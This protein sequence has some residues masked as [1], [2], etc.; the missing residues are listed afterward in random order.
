MDPKDKWRSHPV[1]GAIVSG[2]AILAPFLV[3]VAT[4]AVVGRLL[5]RGHGQ[6]GPALWWAAV[7]VSSTAAFFASERL[8]RRLLPLAA[9]LKM[10]MLFPRGPQNA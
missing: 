7:L 8:F 6:P 3:S 5:P 10:T 4:A 2:A 9:L 1:L